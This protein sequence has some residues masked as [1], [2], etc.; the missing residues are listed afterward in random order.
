MNDPRLYLP[1][2]FTVVTIALVSLNGRRKLV[3]PLI[4]IP[5]VINLVLWAAMPFI[6]QMFLTEGLD[7]SEG[8]LTRNQL[9]IL[10]STTIM[11]L[12]LLH[13]GLRRPLMQPVTSF[14]DRLAPEGRSL[15][16]PTLIVLIVMLVAELRLS[17]VDGGTFAETVSVV[18]TADAGQLAQSGL[19]GSLLML[20][21]GFGFA[22]ISLG[23]REQVT[24]A[25]L[26]LAWAALLMYCA[27]AISRGTRAGVLVPAAAGVI[28]I[29]T[30]RGQV[31]RRAIIGVSALGIVTVA[32]GAPVAAVMGV[33]RN[34]ATI[35]VIAV[36]DAYNT[37]LGGS[38]LGSRV[39]LIATEV[40]RKFDALTPGLELLAMEPPGSAGLR[41][42][43]SAALSPI[44]RI[45]F[46]GKPV[47]TS[48]DGT[49]LGIPYRVAAK[50]FGD[51]ELG[52][53][54]PVSASAIALW[55]FGWLG[56]LV[57]V[58]ANLLSLVL[59]NSV[60]LSKNVYVR[61]IGLSVVGLP[62]CEFFI[63]HPSALVQN[64]LRLCLYL[65]I[66]AMIGLAY[67]QVVR[68]VRLRRPMRDTV[69]VAAGGA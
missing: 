65:A 30:L 40:N 61:A 18:A 12:V 59:L 15:F 10:H 41:P 20:L 39:E 32:I 21:V 48:R 3:S 57:L 27:F 62:I 56:P 14:F 58:L 47:P 49:Q 63:G 17:Q 35:D 53:V 7:T 25:T 1:V 36:Q 66:T 51:P 33:V 16:V 31:R 37:L 9:Q 45:I 64:S 23:R 50:A 38:S 52:Q 69:R 2:L 13:M 60:F 19:L 67:E 8:P 4:T 24:T 42:I 55:E 5:W 26:C 22:V 68:A 44:P 28:A 11:V 29:S 6:I 34:A 54:M 46:P 43:F